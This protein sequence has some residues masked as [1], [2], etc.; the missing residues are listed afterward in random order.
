MPQTAETNSLKLKELNPT[1]FSWD[2]Y[3]H[4]HRSWMK[5]KV[6]LISRLAGCSV[7]EPMK[8]ENG[9]R[10]HPLKK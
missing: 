8:S 3:N 4:A 7:K 10:Q 1:G 9:K 6:G 5:S 2:T